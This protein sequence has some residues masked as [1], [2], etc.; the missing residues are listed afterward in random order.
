MRYCW[1][2]GREASRFHRQATMTRTPEQIAAFKAANL[3]Q[4]ALTTPHFV[5]PVKPPARKT[6]RQE[7]QEL[8]NETRGMIHAAKRQGHLHLMPA[9]AQRLATFESLLQA[10]CF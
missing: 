2:I 5:G 6:Q 4:A 8:L 9:L 10:R 1:D 3:S 7:W